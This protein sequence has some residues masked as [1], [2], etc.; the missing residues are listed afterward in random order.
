MTIIP[1]KI[2]GPIFKGQAWSQ[3]HRHTR[4][5]TEVAQCAYMLLVARLQ[6]KDVEGSYHWK[7]AFE[8]RCDGFMGLG[9]LDVSKECGVEIPD[10]ELIPDLIA[11]AEEAINGCLPVDTFGP[12]AEELVRLG[13]E[14]PIPLPSGGSGDALVDGGDTSSLGDT[15][16]GGD[17]VD[18]VGA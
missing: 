4:T 1:K 8:P 15:S 16:S 7:L 2:G 10:P 12:P 17:V 5:P 11:E 18:G 13:G 6:G 14:D 3:P 9:P